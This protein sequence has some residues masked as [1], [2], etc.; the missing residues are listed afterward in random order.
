MTCAETGELLVAYLDGELE[1]AEEAAVR[2]HLEACGCC[3][4]EA[5]EVRQILGLLAA[6]PVQDE[7]GA[8]GAALAA[9]VVALR[10]RVEW[11]EE[12]VRRLQLQFAAQQ[13]PSPVMAEPHRTEGR[14]LMVV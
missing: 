6:L 9:E 14:L 11:L 7:E 2:E 5:A 3:T 8:P 4:R 1:P 13:A 12:T 10:E